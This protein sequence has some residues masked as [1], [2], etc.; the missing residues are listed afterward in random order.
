MPAWNDP[1]VRNLFE[2]I[3]EYGW[4]LEEIAEE[5]FNKRQPR[6]TDKGQ[7]DAPGKD[8][9]RCINSYPKLVAALGNEPQELE[10]LADQL[11]RPTADI[12][13]IL[14]ELTDIGLLF[15]PAPPYQLNLFGRLSFEQYEQSCRRLEEHHYARKYGS[16]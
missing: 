7:R 5:G 12:E 4:L 10:A 11:D 13:L 3:N 2:T 6:R 1:E 15:E 9:L 8:V 16:N 14:Q